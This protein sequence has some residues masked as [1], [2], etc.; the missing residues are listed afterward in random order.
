MLPGSFLGLGLL[1]EEKYPRSEWYFLFSSCMPQINVAAPPPPDPELGGGMY[2][3]GGIF[4]AK[5]QSPAG[6][7]HVWC[8]EEG[9]RGDG[10]RKGEERQTERTPPKKWGGNYRQNAVL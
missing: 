8:T 10:Q 2:I 9:G 7:R 3:G 1:E 4:V 6:A 5:P